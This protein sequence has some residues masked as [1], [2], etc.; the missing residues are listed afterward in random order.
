MG[1]NDSTCVL[2][3]FWY[4]IWFSFFLRGYVHKVACAFWLCRPAWKPACP[5]PLLY[6]TTHVKGGGFCCCC[7]GLQLSLLKFSFD[8]DDDL[9]LIRTRV[10]TTATTIPTGRPILAEL[11]LRPTLRSTLRRFVPTIVYA[12]C[13]ASWHRR[14]QRVAECIITKRSSHECVW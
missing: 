10:P 7:A 11:L 8:D 3:P 9:G 14:R 12:D 1:L 4:W 6:S 13:V 2:F 5:P